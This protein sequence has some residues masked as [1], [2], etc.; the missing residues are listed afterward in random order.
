M[1]RPGGAT[2]APRVF[3]LM[4]VRDAVDLIRVNVLHHLG[5]GIE[6]LLVCDNGSTDG[7]RAS[8]RE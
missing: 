2:S 1:T 4:V 5:V 8:S 7:V 3:G 6:R